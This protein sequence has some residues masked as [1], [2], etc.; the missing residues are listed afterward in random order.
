ME[1]AIVAVWGAV[2]ALWAA[3]AFPALEVC[4]VGAER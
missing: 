2:F 1:A 3:G 4:E